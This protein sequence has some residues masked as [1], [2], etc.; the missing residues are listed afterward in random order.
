MN[1]NT[2]VFITYVFLKLC[3]K[4]DSNIF[5]KTT[6]CSTVLLQY[7]KYEDVFLE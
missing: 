6:D 4:S 5:Y 1:E 3:R 2:E 7:N